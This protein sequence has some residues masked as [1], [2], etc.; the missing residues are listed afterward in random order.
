MAASWSESH[1][2][3]MELAAALIR[4]RKALSVSTQ[5]DHHDLGIA[6]IEFQVDFADEDAKAIEAMFSVDEEGIH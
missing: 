5:I 4:K 2:R 1:A 6:K 3:M